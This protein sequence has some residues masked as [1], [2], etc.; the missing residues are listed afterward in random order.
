MSCEDSDGV[1]T[2]GA[3][4]LLEVEAGTDDAEIF[5][6]VDFGRLEFW[7]VGVWSDWKFARER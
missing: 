6:S 3:G 7:K 5:F 2:V 4:D 1:G